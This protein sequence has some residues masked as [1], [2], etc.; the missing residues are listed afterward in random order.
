MREATWLSGIAEKCSIVGKQDCERPNASPDTCAN[1]RQDWFSTTFCA[2]ARLPH[3]STEKSVFALAC[4]D[5]ARLMFSAIDDHAVD[6]RLDSK[7]PGRREQQ[8][9]AESSNSRSSPRRS[10][11]GNRRAQVRRQTRRQAGRTDGECRARARH[12]RSGTGRQ[13]RKD[14]ARSGGASR[15]FKNGSEGT[16]RMEARKSTIRERETRQ[17][18]VKRKLKLQR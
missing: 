15:S 12:R 11:S 3:L 6:R 2:S 16:G 13:V 18:E 9:Q 4:T 7:G 5:R 17:V 10:R 1:P 8:A 14:R